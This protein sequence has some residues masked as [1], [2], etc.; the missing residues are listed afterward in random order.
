MALAAF[1]PGLR[2]QNAASAAP[3][4]PAAATN[5]LLITARS[6]HYDHGV[7][8]AIYQGDVRVEDPDMIM[9]CGKMIVR[10]AQPGKNSATNPPRPVATNTPPP[11]PSG[12]NALA[13][14]PWEFDSRRIHSID[15][16]HDVMILLK[17]DKSKASGDKAVF[18][19]IGRAHV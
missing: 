16:E 9:N 13:K 19:E 2:A 6:L 4:V 7:G 17:K 8:V 3:S 18:T 11:A 5:N 12:T 15:A 10:L 1:A 14:S